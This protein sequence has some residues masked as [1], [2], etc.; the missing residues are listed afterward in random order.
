MLTALDS[1]GSGLG[2]DLNSIETVTRTG[3]SWLDQLNS[4]I[5]SVSGLRLDALLPIA[6]LTLLYIAFEIIHHAELKESV[7]SAEQVKTHLTPFQ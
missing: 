1:D 5:V 2:L 4:F 3:L 7:R 6:V